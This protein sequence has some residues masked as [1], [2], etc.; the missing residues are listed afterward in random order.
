MLRIAVLMKFP[1]ITLIKP[2]SALAK[3]CKYKKYT[4]SDEGRTLETS[5][6]KLYY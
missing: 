3:Y 4:R 1:Q 6:M 2:D 5:A